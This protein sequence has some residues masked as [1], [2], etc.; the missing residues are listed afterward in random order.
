MLKLTRS[1]HVRATELAKSCVDRGAPQ[2]L[3]S[4]LREACL[5]EARFSWVTSEA[6]N[7]WWLQIPKSFQNQFL[8]VCI[9]QKGSEV[10]CKCINTYIFFVAFSRCRGIVRRWRPHPLRGSAGWRPRT[11]RYG[12]SCRSWRETSSTGRPTSHRASS[13][14][15][16]S[17]HSSPGSTSTRRHSS[18]PGEKNILW[19]SQHSYWRRSTGGRWGGV[20]DSHNAK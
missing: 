18:S 8:C 2:R 11:R 15:A 12:P 5:W 9:G 14:W 20:P 4:P 17:S 16:T 19:D 6:K 3:T 13:G 10:P 7:T 1:T